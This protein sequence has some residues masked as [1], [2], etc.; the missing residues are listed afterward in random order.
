MERFADAKILGSKV[1]EFRVNAFKHELKNLAIYTS[2]EA[3]LNTA[4]NVVKFQKI[5]SYF[6]NR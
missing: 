5:N 3:G 1:F 4:L 2:V 6:I